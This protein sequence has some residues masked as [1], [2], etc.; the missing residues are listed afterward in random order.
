MSE[1]PVICTGSKEALSQIRYEPKLFDEW[2][3]T[4]LVYQRQS[5]GNDLRKLTLTERLTYLDE[6]LKSAAIEILGEAYNE[7]SWKS[8]AKNQF[9]NRDALVSE[10]VDSL[11]FL[12]NCLAALEVSSNELA[13]KYRGKMNLNTA[14]QKQ[15][16]DTSINKCLVCKRALDDEAVTCTIDRCSEED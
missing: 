12:A 11:F 8:W 6:M 9:L 4:Q 2:L 3:E 14:R 7:L 13:E 5:F 16:Y 10:I 1:Q 15:G